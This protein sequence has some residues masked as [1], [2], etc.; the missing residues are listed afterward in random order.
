MEDL[1]YGML[2]EPVQEHNVQQQRQTFTANWSFK[3]LYSHVRVVAK[4]TLVVSLSQNKTGA[5]YMTLLKPHLLLSC[6]PDEVYKLNLVEKDL[7]EGINHLQDR[8]ENLHKLDWVQKLK[9]GSLVYVA[10]PS[11]PIPVQGTIQYI[12][13]PPREIGRKFFVELMVCC[14]LALCTY[15]MNR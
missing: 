5:N 13:I 2:L 15:C 3:R 11:K 7:I 6:K 4:G 8:F 12:G 9:I 14:I 10:I 1:P